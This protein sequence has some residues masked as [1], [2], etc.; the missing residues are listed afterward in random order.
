[1]QILGIIL[2]ITGA[3][4]MLAGR[5]VAGSIP[6]HYDANEDDDFRAL[7]GQVGKFLKMIGVLLII[8]GMICIAIG[9][10]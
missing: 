6:P 1:M 4:L 10:F 5:N 8:G 2:L 7:L 3:V 9:I